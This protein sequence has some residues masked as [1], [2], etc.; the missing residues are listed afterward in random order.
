MVV[1][2]VGGRG[3]G[4]GGGMLNK[5]QCCSGLSRASGQP[6]AGGVAESGCCNK[7]ASLSTSGCDWHARSVPCP[8]RP[9][10]HLEV[11]DSRRMLEM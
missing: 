7:N 2:V 9:L 5:L 3:A 8:R 6:S 10:A 1:V 11:L 4:G